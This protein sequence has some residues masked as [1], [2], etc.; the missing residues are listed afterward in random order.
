MA[1]RLRYLSR[2]V[3][4]LLLAL[5]AAYL[6]VTAMAHPHVFID[7]GVDLLFSGDRIDGVRLTWTFDDLFSG[8]I[9]QEFDRD[10]NRSLSPAEVQQI[11]A[12]HLAEFR[13]VKFFTVVTLNE[14]LVK[15]LLLGHGKV[16]DAN[17]APTSW[18]YNPAAPKHPY[19]PGRAKMLLDDAGWA[20]GGDGIRAKDG[21]RL[22]FGVMVNNFDATLE[23]VLVVAQQQLRAVGVDLRI[24]RVEPGVFGARRREKRFDALSRVWNPV[25]DPDQTFL[26]RTGNFSGYSNPR[27]DDLSVAALGTVDREVRRRA[28]ADIQTILAQDVARLFLYT[29]DELHAVPVGLRGTQPHPVNFFWNVKDWTLE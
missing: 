5:G 12:K 17:V 23:Q 1:R 3:R 18:A 19:D 10:R 20:P 14:G 27:V 26:V 25:Y 24:E 2:G 22:S 8:F 16:M 4:I 6:P 29:Q 28:Y 9:L 7:C 13:R 21:Q 15:R 11:E